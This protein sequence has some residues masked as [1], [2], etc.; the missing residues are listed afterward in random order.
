M[1]RRPMTP[2]QK[3]ALAILIIT[4]V[5]IVILGLGVG[6]L[7]V[8]I[9]A[10]LWI[11]VAIVVVVTAAVGLFGSILLHELAHAVVALRCGIP[12]KRIC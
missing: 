6:W 10:P 3:R 12:M 11:A 8:S 2:D 9:G 1:S 4:G 5:V 7:A